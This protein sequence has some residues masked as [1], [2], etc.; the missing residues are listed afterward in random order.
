[1]VP[2]ARSNSRTAGG[3]RGRAARSRRRALRSHRPVTGWR[4]GQST[5]LVAVAV[6]RH[7]V[8]GE[9]RI[10]RQHRPARSDCAASADRAVPCADRAVVSAELGWYLPRVR[11]VHRRAGTGRRAIGFARCAQ[12]KREVAGKEGRG[13]ERIRQSAPLRGEISAHGPPARERRYRQGSMGAKPELARLQRDE[14]DAAVGD[15]RHRSRQRGAQAPAERPRKSP[16]RSHPPRRTRP[17]AAAIPGHD[18][19]HR[20]RGSVLRVA[21][22]PYL[23][24]ARHRDGS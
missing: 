12:S 8:R 19:R 2:C 21:A 24:M 23:P 18:L 9:E 14:A 7:G 3:Q 13:R 6:M 1:M 22:T 11:V 10:E 17:D 4:I 15:G 5:H 16:Q 20:V